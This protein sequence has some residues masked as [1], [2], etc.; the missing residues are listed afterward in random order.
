[1]ASEPPPAGQ[2]G[3]ERWR[4]VPDGEPKTFLRLTRAKMQEAIS[5]AAKEIRLDPWAGKAIKVKYQGRDNTW[6]WGAEVIQ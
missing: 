2:A 5:P 4:F 6:V 1:V 3:T